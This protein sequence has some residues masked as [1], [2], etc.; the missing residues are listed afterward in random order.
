MGVRGRAALKDIRADARAQADFSHL[1]PISGAISA[2][3]LELARRHI[4]QAGLEGKITVYQRDLRD[5]A[6]VRP[7][8]VLPGAI[9]PMASA[10]GIAKPASSCTAP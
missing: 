7:R 8:T 4:R 1:P 3:A 5:L 6:A 2:R 10:W 9:R